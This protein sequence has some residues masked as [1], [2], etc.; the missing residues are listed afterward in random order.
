MKQRSPIAVFFLTLLTFGIYGIVWQVKTKNEMNK[1]GAEIPTAWLIIVPFVSI[2]WLWKYSEGVEKVTN[3][4]L[5]AVLAFVLQFLLGIIGASIIQNDFNK[6]SGLAVAGAP[7]AMPVPQPDASFGGP[8][9]PT[10][11]V[12]PGS[13]PTPGATMPIAPPA[14]AAP[15]EP[16]DAQPSQQQ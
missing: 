5:S 7:G 9:T 14:P 10:A 13:M 15:I 1:L 16:T 12:A 3:G 4:S 8:A 6:L 2:Y 11:P